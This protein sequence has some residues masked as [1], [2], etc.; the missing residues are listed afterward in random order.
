[1]DYFYIYLI[2]M[3]F[4]AF[5]VSMRRCEMWNAVAFTRLMESGFGS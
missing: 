3:R 1:M 4:A 2:E 5:I